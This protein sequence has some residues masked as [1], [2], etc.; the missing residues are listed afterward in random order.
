MNRSIMM[1]PLLAIAATAT[2]ILIR[3]FSPS[4]AMDL[5]KMLNPDAAVQP[6]SVFHGMGRRLGLG[7]LG[8]GLIFGFSALLAA[9]FQVTE[10]EP[11]V[12]TADASFLIIPAFIAVL[13]AV[14]SAR[15]GLNQM[16]GMA[17]QMQSMFAQMQPGAEQPPPDDDGFTFEGE[18]IEPEED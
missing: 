15:I 2:T 13:G 4:P 1:V 14:I 17:E 8:Y 7:I 6:P 11:Q 18:I 5:N 3:K 9:L 12:R 16:S 10:F